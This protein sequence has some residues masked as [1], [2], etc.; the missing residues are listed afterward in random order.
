[1]QQSRAD[2]QLVMCQ[3]IAHDFG[4]DHNDENFSNTNTRHVHG[5]W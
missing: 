2:R 3:E 5:L 4:L 1:M